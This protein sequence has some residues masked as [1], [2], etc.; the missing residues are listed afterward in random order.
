MESQSPTPGPLQ[1][2]LIDQQN[3]L[4]GDSE[5]G[6]ATA[7]APP[8]TPA[9][10]ARATISQ[11]NFPSSNY[12]FAPFLTALYEENRDLG[13]PAWDDDKDP[14]NMGGKGHDHVKGPRRTPRRPGKAESKYMVYVPSWTSPEFDIDREL[15]LPEWTWRA[16]PRRDATQRLRP[17]LL[18]QDILRNPTDYAKRWGMHP[19][20]RDGR[21]RLSPANATSRKLTGILQ[22]QLDQ[23]PLAEKVLLRDETAKRQNISIDPDS[24]P[25]LEING[26]AAVD[27]DV[28]EDYKRVKGMP[29]IAD[30]VQDPV[31][32]THPFDMVAAGLTHEAREYSK[33]L[34]QM[35]QDDQD[36]QRLLFHDMTT[37][38]LIRQNVHTMS[39]AETCDLDL[40]EPLHPLVTRDLWVNCDHTGGDRYNPRF[41]YSM[42]GIREEWQAADNDRVW[43]A[44]Q[45][46]LQ[47]VSR[48][49]RQR[50]RVWEA[51]KDLRT[52]QK[53]DSSYDTR[54][55]PRTTHLVKMVAVDDI[56]LDLCWEPVQRLTELGFNSVQRVEE[57]LDGA[58]TYT[59]GTGFMDLYGGNNK[60]DA[61]TYGITGGFES[62]DIEIRL[63][64]ELV[65]PLLV[66]EYSN[67]EK[68][69]ASWSVASTLLHEIM[70]A[71]SYAV[72][73]LCVAEGFSAVHAPG[74]P[75]EI[76]RLLEEVGTQMIDMNFG[77]GEP[78]FQDD[79]WTE[80]GFAFEM[81]HFG[82]FFGSLV[83]NVLLSKM[84]TYVPF[85]LMGSR[86]PSAVDNLVLL[87]TIKT[88]DVFQQPVPIDWF[89]RFFQ[90]TF[91][92]NDL[93]KWGPVAYKLLPPDRSLF[94]LKSNAH[95]NREAFVTIVGRGN[96]NF[97]RTVWGLLGENGLDILAKYCMYSL[98]EIR[99]Y[100]M[101]SSRWNS[102]MEMWK[103]HSDEAVFPIPRALEHFNVDLRVAGSILK[104]FLQRE[105]ATTQAWWYDQYPNDGAV[106]RGSESTADWCKRIE[107]FFQIYWKADGGI[108]IRHVV[109]IY[110]LLRSDVE[111]QLLYAYEYFSVNRNGRRFLYQGRGRNREPLT[112]ILG[113]LN[114]DREAADEVLTVLDSGV[115]LPSS[116]NINSGRWQ[117]WRQRFEL[118]RDTAIEMLNQVQAD[119]HDQLSTE[120]VQGLRDRNT[121]VPSSFARTKLDKIRKLA[122]REA[123]LVDHRIRDAL[124]EFDRRVSI[125]KQNSIETL[126][127]DG[128]PS[129]ADFQIP[130][131]DDAAVQILSSGNPISSLPPQDTNQSGQASVPSSGDARV[132]MMNEINRHL[133]WLNNSS[134]RRRPPLRDA[135]SST[136]SGRISKSSW[137]GTTDQSRTG[138][139]LAN[140]KFS[141]FLPATTNIQAQLHGVV[142][143]STIPG[144]QA[145]NQFNRAAGPDL[146]GRVDMMG[147]PITAAPATYSV[148]YSDPYA[149]PRITTADSQFAMQ[150]Q[151]LEQI[152]AAAS[153][154]GPPK[155]GGFRDPPVVVTD[156][157]S[158]DGVQ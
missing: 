66:P 134:G 1:S 135:V 18:P 108:I 84:I 120:D 123:M 89:H 46:A 111:K 30:I 76:S 55:D 77:S 156:D 5:D 56:N 51:L 60:E 98:W 9:E 87:D 53:I 23:L 105:E 126:F 138:L 124:M 54:E 50:P 117:E 26:R 93:P 100:S 125:F 130:S 73:A 122:Q 136:L 119:F 103:E 145:A 97:F 35:I 96:M 65:W 90:T 94:T 81:D 153:G 36:W 75:Q 64:A 151:Q 92:E 104:C 49:L 38:E 59:I 44:L 109:E 142:P 33:G 78:F 69:A 68:L 150:Q 131:L 133:P 129:V 118:I 86:S 147:R 31:V 83:D 143:Q 88:A 132:D 148:L 141:S 57:V 37:D 107:R 32:Q 22:A 25:A 121:L 154:N 82:Q 114:A 149:G 113:F 127:P 155:F 27:V 152:N 19:D 63:A 112:W 29:R 3:V 47:I 13:I 14:I 17:A 15:K 128:T 28:F 42:G 70:H 52:R 157:S 2:D 41:V 106:N 79:L 4:G 58:V 72:A 16:R 21:S 137:G 110:T 116:G 48:I 8:Q 34:I 74:Q 62:Q 39:N 43:D 61:F 99:D 71:T 7:P 85:A 91:W 95:W 139:G 11:P 115:N 101:I 20:R 45:P 12:D 24:A 80:T 140:P 158:D 10:R 6:S 102:Q 67:S 144:P 146:Q 40:T